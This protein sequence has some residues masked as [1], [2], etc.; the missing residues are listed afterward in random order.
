MGHRVAELS[1]FPQL[2]RDPSLAEK[3]NV[4]LMESIASGRLAPG[5]RLPSERELCDQFGVSR[6]VIREAVRGLQAKGVLRVRAGRGAEIVAVPASQITETIRLFL[7]GAGSQELLDAQKISEVRD[8]LELRLVELAC[9]RASDD[10]L[11]RMSDAVEA[12][13]DAKTTEAAS[14]HDV[15]FH[16]LIA[17]ATKNGLF[18]VLLDSV[19]DVLMEIRRRS[20]ALPGR[21]E[22]AVAEHRRVLEA[23]LA[24]DV[25]TARAAMSDHLEGSQALYAPAVET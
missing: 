22:Q 23:L 9:A 1:A 13:A 14:E 10:D 16:R 19:G 8:T 6:T 12:M 24:R 2:A 3:V 7:Q 21:T 17:A 15:E 25:V 5:D 4:A 20:L 18:V 11:R